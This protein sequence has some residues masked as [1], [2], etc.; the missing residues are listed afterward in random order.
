MKRL[1]FTAR[2]DP[3]RAP[4]LFVLLAASDH[5]REARLLDWNLGSGE[6]GTL[7]YAV[8]GDPDAFRAAARETPGVESVDVEPAGDGRFHALLDARPSAVPLL[9]RVLA[10]MTRTGMVVLTPVVYRDGTVSGHIVGDAATLQ[11]TLDGVPDAVD[12][13]VEEVGP[14]RGPP[15]TPETRLSDRQREAV[16]VALEL[17]YYEHPSETTHEAIAAE[18]DCAPSTASEHLKKAEAK[19]VRGGL[20]DVGRD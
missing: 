3:S 16:L 17:G 18:L 6:R 7:L 5:A 12:V 8:D 4:A 1:H 10:A 11:A 13:T 9:R 14:F 20:T 2:P 19:L 15:G